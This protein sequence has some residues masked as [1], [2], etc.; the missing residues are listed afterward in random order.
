MPQR[1]HRLHFLKQKTVYRCGRSHPLPVP[2]GILG[3][4]Y[5]ISCLNATGG[6]IRGY[7]S[8]GS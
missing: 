2:G 7:W 5:N 4:Y 6:R 8:S 3:E 1:P